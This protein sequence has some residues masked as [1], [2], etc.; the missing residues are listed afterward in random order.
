[1]EGMDPSTQPHPTRF[2]MAITANSRYMFEILS[3]DELAAHPK[4]GLKTVVVSGTCT[5]AD[6][7]SFDFIATNN[8][9]QRYPERFKVNWNGKAARMPKV[10]GFGIADDVRTGRK[11]TEELYFTRG[12]RIAI[13]RKCKELFP[14][15]KQAS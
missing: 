2:I 13:A 6:G 3:S 9:D 12:A 14:L 15:W 10:V 5:N 7:V 8:L 4:S 11:V 1:M